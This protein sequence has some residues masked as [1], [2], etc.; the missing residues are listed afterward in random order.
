MMTESDRATMVGL[1]RCLEELEAAQEG[2]VHTRKYRMYHT[3]YVELYQMA[4]KLREGLLRSAPKARRP[5]NGQ[6]RLTESQPG[7]LTESHT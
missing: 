3:A 4:Y 2:H 1:F 6:G 7:R 5:G